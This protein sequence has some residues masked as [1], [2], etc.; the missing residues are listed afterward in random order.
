MRE[1]TSEEFLKDVANHRFTV[2][3]D[4]GIYRHLRLSQPQNSNQW[5]EIVTWPGVLIIHGDMG[6]WTFSRIEDMFNFFRCSTGLEINPQYWAEKLEAGPH[7]GHR[8]AKV[9]ENEAFAANMLWHL[10]QYDFTPEELA[11]ITAAVKREILSCE[12]KW[13]I[14]AAVRDFRHEFTNRT[15]RDKKFYLDLSEFPDGEVYSYHYL[16]CCYA[17]VWGI[18]QWDASKAANQAT[19][20]LSA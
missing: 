13:E 5:F 8:T 20:A 7:N 14:I 11:E 9:W 16:W 15:G 2:K 19:E 18:Q 17:I 10:A 4:N 3:L 6:T 1:P 12:D